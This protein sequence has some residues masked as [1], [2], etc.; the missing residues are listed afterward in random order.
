[1]AA[2]CSWKMIEWEN[3]VNE[4]EARLFQIIKEVW[5]SGLSL[6]IFSFH[7]NKLLVIDLQ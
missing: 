6:I 2:E 3:M 5:Y 1:M 4:P 7:V